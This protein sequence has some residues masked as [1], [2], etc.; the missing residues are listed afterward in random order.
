MIQIQLVPVIKGAAL[1]G[2]PANKQEQQ[3]FPKDKDVVFGI[4]YR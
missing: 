1:G 4:I 3:Q 2:H